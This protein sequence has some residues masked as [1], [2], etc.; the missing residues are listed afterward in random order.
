MNGIS[1][2]EQLENFIILLND[3]NASLPTGT[4]VNLPTNADMMKS[5]TGSVSKDN[6][7]R[8]EFQY[9]ENG[10]CATIWL[11]NNVPMWEIGYCKHLGNGLYTVEHLERVKRDKDTKWRHKT[12]RMYIM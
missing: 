12:F 4:A 6:N 9:G 1:H 2:E 5:L 11:I 10:M 3:C 8:S 7:D